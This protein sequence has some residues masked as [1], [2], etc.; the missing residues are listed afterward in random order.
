MS[1]YQR[2]FPYPS[3]RDAQDEAIRFALDA[4]SQG[5]RF[6]VIEAGTGVG[7][8]A[9][10]LTVSR[11]INNSN[12]ILPEGITRGSWYV[13]TQKVL[14]DQ[15]IKDFGSLGM[16]SIKSATNYS[17]SF[18][19]GNT[20]AESQKL[21]RIEEKGSRFWNTCTFSCGYKKDK[22]AFIDAADSVTNFPYFLTEASYSGKITSRELLVIDEAHN[23]EAELS[24]FVEVA[25]SERFVKTLLKS[26][27]S[28]IRTQHQ[29]HTWLRDIYYPKLVKHMKHIES[30]MEKFSGIQASLKKD[31]ETSKNKL[32][33][34]KKCFLM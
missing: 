10:G 16:R 8:S 7:K 18:K 11:V 30:M 12:N 9:I 4:Y 25:V 20:C 21:L 22:E 17:C 31:F 19:K 26:G 24:K 32:N 5:K 28:S 2:F 27:F 6:V 23:T 13:T 29:A 33:L 34:L 15:Y 3:P 14:Q 1:S